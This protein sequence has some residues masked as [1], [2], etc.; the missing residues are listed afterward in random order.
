MKNKILSSV[1]VASSLLMG[2]AFADNHVGGVESMDGMEHVMYSSATA[3]LSIPSFHIKD[4]SGATLSTFMSDLKLTKADLPYELQVVKLEAVEDK[5]DSDSHEHNKAVFLTTTNTLTLPEVHVVN[6]EG[7]TTEK[8]SAT[9]TIKSFSPPFTLQV[10][11]LETVA[12]SEMPSMDMPK[13]GD[14]DSNGCVYPET[15]HASMNHC[16]DQTGAK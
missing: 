12:I 1:L 15:W 10:T 9:L 6:A 5:A 13:P 16:M 11:S 4:A 7:M 2:Q 14:V 8:L 3:M